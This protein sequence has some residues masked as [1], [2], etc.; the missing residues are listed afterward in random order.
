[1]NLVNYVKKAAVIA[2]GSVVLSG[3]LLSGEAQ[4]IDVSNGELVLAI[5]GNDN[6]YMLDLGSESS[7][8]A[9]NSSTSFQIP[10]GSDSGSLESALS[11]DNPVQW[12][13]VGVS[14]N[15]TTGLPDL[16]AGSSA[17]AASTVAPGVQNAAS[18][19]ANWEALL[20]GVGTSTD[21]LVAAS[22]SASF[23]SQFGTNSLGG[24]FAT[25][26]QGG[27]GDM[28]YM[29]SADFSTSALTDV[30]TASLVLG[31]SL[32]LTVCGPGNNDCLVTGPTV[33]VP[34]SVVLFATGLV[35]LVGLAR[36]KV[37]I[38][39]GGAVC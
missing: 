11:G 26:M 1:M 17:P 18:L 33:P 22:N 14:V 28:L 16:F 30:G 20:G 9:S 6:E 15:Q 13:I 35:G 32:D 10:W 25:N 31:N 24:S 39:D 38:D 21:A 4:A 5:F 23:T 37:I 19:V 2:A 29:I 27:I 36:R 34:A 7:L 12:A 3:A 8:L